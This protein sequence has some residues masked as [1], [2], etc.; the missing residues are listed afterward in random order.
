MSIGNSW[1][2]ISWPGLSTNGCLVQYLILESDGWDVL[3]EVGWRRR[4]RLHL[5]QRSSFA[6]R[7]CKGFPTVVIWESSKIAL[8]V[9]TLVGIFEVELELD[10]ASS[11]AAF[12]ETMIAA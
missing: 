2:Y 1:P 7:V 5:G 3:P 12:K 6:G 10:L 8:S 11:L 9:E 4:G